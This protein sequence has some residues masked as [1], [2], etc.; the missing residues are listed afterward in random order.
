MRPRL[1]HL[2]LLLLTLLPVPMSA[3]AQAFAPT[4]PGISEIKTIPAARLLR[5]SGERDYFESSGRLFRPLFRY[6][7]E[8]E[9]RMTVPVEAEIEPGA[10]SFY[11]GRDAEG[12]PLED[13][14]EVEVIELPARQVASRGM[15]GGYS[16]ENFAQAR[17]ALEAWLAEHPEWVA[18]GPA[19][20]IYWHGPMTPFFLKRAEVH[21]PVA[22]RPAAEEPNLSGR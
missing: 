22:P 12:R 16:E 11:V 21:I 5:A 4:E 20:A 14:D 7:Q 15:R 9:I 10:M 2:L 3:A 18:T 17:D 8:H 1:P 13:A 19:R 6:I